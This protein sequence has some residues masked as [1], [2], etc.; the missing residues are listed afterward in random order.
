M[1]VAAGGTTPTARRSWTVPK[2]L[3]LDAILWVL[4][5]TLAAIYAVV[6]VVQLPANIRALAWNSDYAS[7]F[8]IPE[9]V[10]SFGTGGHLVLA[11][12]GQWVSLWFGL[13]TAHLPLHREL[14]GVAPTLL[15]LT[16]V[17]LVGWSVRQLA[18]RRPAVVAVLI[19]FVASPSALVLFLAPVAHNMVYP[20]TA[21]IGVYVIWLAR[22]GE[23]QRWLTFGVPPLA[24]VM[25][26][27]CLASDSLVAA[28]AL[29]PLGV[30]AIL[31]GVQGA[32]RSRILSLSTVATIAVALPVAKLT[33]AIMHSAGY[34]TLPS[35]VSVAPLSELPERA[36]LLFRGL[37]TLF[38][39]NL[40]PAEPGTLH[41][42]L[43]IASDIAMSAALFALIALGSATT[44]RLLR[45]AVGKQRGRAMPE[46]ARSL[47]LVYWISS[48]AAAC[49]VFWIAAETGGSTNVHESYYA[50]VIFSVAA[51]I[52]LLSQRKLAVRS[53]VAAGTAVIF[54]ASLVGL[55]GK[56]MKISAWVAEGEARVRQVALANH[57]SVGYGGYG[58]ASSLT[59]NTNGHV[60]I[61]PLMECANPAGAGICPFYMESVPAWYVP[62]RRHTFLL[63]DEEE[64]WVHTLPSGL[65]KP[66][67]AYSFGAMRMYIYPYD[68]ASRLGP[69]QD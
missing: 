40:G 52:P 20:C 30:V 54:L 12:S 3:E 63:I 46:L 4:P 25:L 33:S 22:E 64:A 14:W 27:T 21:L 62:H 6:F 57:V 61:R 65:G 67:A 68:I 60:T 42:P 47:H 9:A 17:L 43:G 31:G 58:E 23:R 49:G 15:F 66:L 18:G 26:G 5:L 7:G 55:A 29:I 16:T 48:A 2:R 32:S 56:Y 11:S 59:W 13:L 69:A 50:N 10:A 53:L 39:G 38:N 45:S 44:F 1:P 36:E 41:A 24:G 19:G 37:K 28:T 35:P 34:V 51:V 8:T